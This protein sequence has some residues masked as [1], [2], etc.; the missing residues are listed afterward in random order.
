MPFCVN[1]PSSAKKIRIRS[2][3]ATKLVKAAAGYPLVVLA[4]WAKSTGSLSTSL[5]KNQL[6]DTTSFVTPKSCGLPLLSGLVG[7]TVPFATP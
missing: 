6:A 4:F 5:Q 2:C 7:A 3:S 1:K